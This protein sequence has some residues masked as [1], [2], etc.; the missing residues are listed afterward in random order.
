MTGPIA[1]LIFSG[2]ILTVVIILPDE[3]D[4]MISEKKWY[5]NVPYTRLTEEIVTYVSTTLSLYGTKPPPRY[6]LYYNSNK[7]F[8]GFY[9]NGVMVIYTKNHYSVPE[10]I[11]TVVHECFHHYQNV[12]SKDFRKHYREFSHLGK[13]NPYEIA[14]R[15]Y[16][17]E[18]LD[19]CLTYLNIKG[20]IYLI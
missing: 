17:N 13:N 12:V 19:L 18:N 5:S 4:E 7:K 6:R 14:A 9:Q 10:Y 3:T 15:K 20:I 11:D 16:A 1:V 8:K 2:I